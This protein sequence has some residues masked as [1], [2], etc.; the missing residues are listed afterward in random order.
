M[1]SLFKF[2]HRKSTADYII[3]E[4]HAD[5]ILKV[6]KRRFLDNLNL[7]HT[8]YIQEI[9]DPKTEKTVNVTLCM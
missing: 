8:N 4:R 1:I 9:R 7:F 6:T 2:S 5:S 3:F